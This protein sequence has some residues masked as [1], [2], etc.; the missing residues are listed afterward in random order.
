ML[1][2]VGRETYNIGGES[3]QRNIELV[4]TLCALLDDAR[5]RK[6]GRYTDLITFVADR[7]GHD[8]RYAMNIARI[9]GELGWQPKESFASGLE[10]TVGWYLANGAWVEDVTSGAYRRWVEQNYAQRGAA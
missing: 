9:R 8:R 7:P 5:P 3:E 2:N 6:S 10:K 1:E 4:K